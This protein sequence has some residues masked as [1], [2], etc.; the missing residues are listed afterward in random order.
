M[1]ATLEVRASKDVHVGDTDALQE[2]LV[3]DGCGT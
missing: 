1:P 2:V 3:V